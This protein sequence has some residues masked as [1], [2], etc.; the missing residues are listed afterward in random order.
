MQ[1]I[2]SLL[3]FSAIAAMFG[4]A[5]IFC[6]WAL[7][8]LWHVVFKSD[9]QSMHEYEHTARDRPVVRDRLS[10]ERGQERRT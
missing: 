3:V 2:M 8:M 1:I 7:W 10:H 9:E 5:V 6:G 4:G